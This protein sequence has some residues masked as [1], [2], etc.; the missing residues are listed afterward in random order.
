MLGEL[1]ARL[2]RLLV[3]A[4]EE[5]EDARVERL[6]R[7]EEEAVRRLDGAEPGERRAVVRAERVQHVR[8]RGQARVY[9]RRA[10]ARGD[11]RI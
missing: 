1:V 11:G 9:L 6:G 7:R 8:V 2:V 3:D 5:V 4:V 10:C